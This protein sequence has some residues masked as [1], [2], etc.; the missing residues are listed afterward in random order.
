MGQRLIGSK[1]T[2]QTRGFLSLATFTAIARKFMVSCLVKMGYIHSLP[3]RVEL[4]ASL[5]LLTVLLA[6]LL[7]LASYGLAVLLGYTMKPSQPTW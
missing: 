2:N 7:A 5:G 6:F 4:C 3:I 1:L